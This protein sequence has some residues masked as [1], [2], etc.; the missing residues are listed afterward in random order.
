MIEKTTK[1]MLYFSNINNMRTIKKHQ[2]D[3]ILNHKL[4]LIFF[5]DSTKVESLRI[6]LFY[7][8]NFYVLSS[9]LTPPRILFCFLENRLFISLFSKLCFLLKSSES[10][11]PVQQ[12]I[13]IP[14]KT[15]K[16]DSNIKTC[17]ICSWK[18]QL[19]QLASKK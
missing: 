16:N 4:K 19:H 5:N 7:L 18:T 8:S 3:N 6:S 12:Q 2:F 14:L 11:I 15:K 13:I 9:I 10:L 1:I 17:S